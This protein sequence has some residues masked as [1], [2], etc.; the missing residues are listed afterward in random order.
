MT[1][2]FARC[3]KSIA[4]TVLLLVSIQAVSQATSLSVY[5]AYASDELVEECTTVSPQTC[6]LNHVSQS[7][8]TVAL[9]EGVANHM[10]SDA[11]SLVDVLSQGEYELLASAV[12]YSNN[13]DTLIHFEYTLN[14]RGIPIFE[15]RITQPEAML[16]SSLSASINELLNQLQSDQVLSA[17]YLFAQLNAS[18]YH[19]ELTAPSNVDGFSLQQKA[20]Q[21]DPTQGVVLRYT[22][23]HY[24]NAI[25]DLFVYP[26]LEPDFGH[27]PDQALNKELDKDK[28]SIK[29]IASAR[30][31][32]GVSISATKMV[33]LNDVNNQGEH[34]L[35]VQFEAQAEETNEPLHTTQYLFIKEDKFVKFSANIP[36]QY[37]QKMV[38]QV[39]KN[40][41]VPKASK[42]MDAFRAV[43]RQ[44]VIDTQQ[45]ITANQPAQ[46]ITAGR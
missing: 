41:S 44:M 35:G 23:D 2:V 40:L 1:I 3:S 14:W 32:Q 27:H 16:M 24:P 12:R 29:Q 5:A 18:D 22:H 42:I 39:M 26:V 31:I 33:V 8:Y 10:W 46:A 30:N 36:A 6:L 20:L 19:H 9:V 25:I 15:S 4:A 43:N 34:I 45:Q 28:H 17:E 13:N 11:D 38:E 21:A 37:T 7:Q